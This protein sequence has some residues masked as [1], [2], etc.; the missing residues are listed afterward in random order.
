MTFNTNLTIPFRTTEQDIDG[1][2]RVFMQ[3][4][5]TFPQFPFDAFQESAIEVALSPSL[6][7]LYFS[8]KL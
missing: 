4:S 6:P 7:D 3:V 8:H 5:L 1:C 2:I